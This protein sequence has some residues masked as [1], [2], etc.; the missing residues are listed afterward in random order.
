MGAVYS[1]LTSIASAIGGLIM[2]IFRAIGAA[3]SAVVSAIISEYHDL[4]TPHL[5]HSYESS[6]RLLTP[7]IAN[8]IHHHSRLRCHR[9]MPHL[10]GLR[11]T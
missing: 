5:Q 7:A 8:P 6:D 11:R 2:G 10:P 1:C 9:R 3:L 4:P